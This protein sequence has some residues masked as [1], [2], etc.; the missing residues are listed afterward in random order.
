MFDQVQR[1]SEKQIFL[2]FVDDK[3]IIWRP[4]I[5]NPRVLSPVE[6]HIA[7]LKFI[8]I[9]NDNRMQLSFYVDSPLYSASENGVFWNKFKITIEFSK[10][11]GGL[12][13]KRILYDVFES[14]N[15]PVPEERQYSEIKMSVSKAV[16]NLNNA[17]PV[18]KPDISKFRSDSYS[19]SNSSEFSFDKVKSSVTKTSLHLVDPFQKSVPFARSKIPSFSIKQASKQ[20]TRHVNSNDEEFWD[21]P[22][23]EKPAN[24][25]INT[26]INKSFKKAVSKITSETTSRSFDH[27]KY[28]NTVSTTSTFLSNKLPKKRKERSSSFCTETPV[29]STSDISKS[30]SY[31]LSAKKSFPDLDKSTKN[32][33]IVSTSE[34]SKNKSMLSDAG[35]SSSRHERALKR[36]KYMEE[37]QALAAESFN[38]TFS[39]KFCSPQD[40]R[41]IQKKKYSKKNIV[42]L[43][44]KSCNE[45]TEEKTK[46]EQN[47]KQ[48]APRN[49]KIKQE[50]QLKKK[51]SKPACKKGNSSCQKKNESIKAKENYPVLEIKDKVCFKGNECISHEKK[52]NELEKKEKH[53][54]RKENIVQEKQ[55]IVQKSQ[56]VDE[57]SFRAAQVNL[58]K[59]SMSSTPTNEDQPNYTEKS[60]SKSFADLNNMQLDHLLEMSIEDMEDIDDSFE[61]DI[62]L[63][64]QENSVTQN[65]PDS[66]YDQNIHVGE[67]FYKSQDLDEIDIIESSIDEV[68]P[69]LGISNNNSND[70]NSILKVKS[71]GNPLVQ[72]SEK[73]TLPE[74]TLGESL[75]DVTKISDLAK[76][77][78][79]AKGSE[80]LIKP[81]S[82][83]FSLPMISVNIG[84]NIIPDRYVSIV[85]QNDKM[86]K[87]KVW[88][89]L[90]V[91]SNTDNAKF[92]IKPLILQS[93]KA[94]DI[95]REQPKIDESHTLLEVKEN[96]HTDERLPWMQ[97]TVSQLQVN[98]KIRIV[99]GLHDLRDQ[100]QALLR[101][102]TSALLKRL[103][104]MEKEVLDCDENFE[105]WF[106]REAERVEKKT[107]AFVSDM[108][109]SKSIEEANMYESK[110]LKWIG[111]RKRMKII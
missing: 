55:Q 44:A 54:N 59:Q 8:Y 31:G 27:S 34:S 46:K 37:K 49:Q 13:F 98:E 22:K 96:S 45:S 26:P 39:S 80:Y 48:Q 32:N 43:Q 72:S 86:A 58:E 41:S 29:K 84:E 100:S 88:P 2:E 19:S 70:F 90:S 105:K 57:K 47:K 110:L 15:F 83:S 104:I 51:K 77:Q 50:D 68:P 36:Q 25:F 33:E 73:Q 89:D 20:N 60:S 101:C 9:Y 10:L 53:N 78:P 64:S 61:N 24:A 7:A 107:Q 12:K 52:E 75:K 81:K 30:S 79:H 23:T 18:L 95:P 108:K 1:Y 74:Q 17:A 85:E 106:L 65:K 42:A 4:H 66:F 5:K 109:T 14:R 63:N 40:P 69:R 38:K 102:V 6:I 87:N 103:E 3:F 28:N 35:N 67:N 11:T 82:A 94:S 62:S 97:P 93:L 56:E 16:I 91:Q 111:Q 92:C 99:N 76:T 21:F 71:S